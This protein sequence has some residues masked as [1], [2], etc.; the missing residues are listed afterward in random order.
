MQIKTENLCFSFGNNKVLNNINIEVNSCEI[1]SVLGPNGVGKTTLFRCLLGFLNPQNGAVYV[2]NRDI[3]T[4]TKKDLSSCIAYI[5]QS[6]SPAF[7]NTV[8]DSVLMGLS[9]QIG[10][11]EEPGKAHVEKA[12]AVLKTLGIDQ[13]ADRGC[14]KISGGERSLMLMARALV[15][16]AKILIMDEPTANLDLGNSL[17]VMDKIKQ[18]KDD[19][20]TVILS[21]HDPNLAL[22]LSTRII[23]LKDGKVLSDGKPED[24]TDGILSEL[25]GIDVEKCRQC[26]RISIKL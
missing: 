1:V 17:K 26:N 16:D 7:N 3:S 8:L 15:Q 20:Y 12:M 22:N 19:G 5:P 4:Y 18:L 6:Y 11:F 10:L 9:N 25:Y 23:T 21:T 2:D 13:L 14:L 24:L